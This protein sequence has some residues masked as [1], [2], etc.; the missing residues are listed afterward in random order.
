MQRSKATLPAFSAGSGL[1]GPD[2][3]EHA[4]ET[5]E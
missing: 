4:L 1:A 5:A 2:V 3:V